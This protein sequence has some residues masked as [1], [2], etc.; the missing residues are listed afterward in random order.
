MKLKNI[1]FGL[2]L[3][4]LLALS[5]CADDKF[6]E[7]RTDMTKNLKEYQYLNNY[8]PLKKYVEDMKASGKCNPD[9]KLGIALA[10]PDFN[11][12][13]LV[14][15]LAGSNF[16]EMTAGNAMKYASCVKDDGTFDF[17]TVKDF[18]TNAKDAGLTI[19][20]HTLA[21]H[22][23]QNK[24]YLSKL[25]AD[26][27]IQ[28]DP[29]QKEEKTDYQL[30]CSTLTKY[31]WFD[32][33]ASSVTTEWNKDGAVVITN[34]EPIEPFYKLQYWLV[35]GI[36]L[37]EGKDYK[38]TIECKAEG[39]S[40]ANIHFKLGD[41]NV[42]EQQFTIP[43]G[44]GY[45]KVVLS[46]SPKMANNGIMF[47]HG[48]FAGKIYWKSIT[49]SHMETPVME[50][51]STV[52]KLD[53]EGEESLG[54]WGMDHTP[55]NV[56]GVCQVGN[57]AA[58]SAD[59]NAQVNFEP[60]FIFE[61]GTTYHLKMKIKGSVAGQFGALFQNPDGY[62][63]CGNFQNISVT[64][65]WKEVDVTAK[66]NGD[67]ASRLLLNIGL[68]AG[69]L[70]IDDFEVYITK[71]ANSIPLTDEEK[72]S[73]LTDAMGKWI[74][75]MME[76]TD[77]YVTSWDVVNEALSG[78]DKDGD[79]K[80]DLQHAATASADDKKN[81]FY[82]QDYLGDIDY[83][84]TAVAA[85]RK[86]FAAHNG[87]PDKLKLFINDYNL[88]S[89]WDE[90]AKLESLKKWIDD[91]EA[92]GV[93][94]IDGIASQMHI[95]CYADPNTQKSKK[96]HIVKMLELMA[97]SGKLCKISELDMGYVDAA[98]NKLTYDQMTEEQHKEMRDLYTFVLQKYFEII[99]IDQQYGITQ[100]CA[101]DSPKDSGWRPGEPTGLWDLNYLRKHTYAGFA[102]GLGAP[103]Y[104]NDAK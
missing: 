68:Y 80:Y 101:T 62:K 98:G 8:E 79:G 95:T 39:A 47:Q 66:C 28:V 26:K 60:G 72:K 71:S 12:Q 88:E 58:K 24:T 87:D 21:W 102:A 32:P 25:I 27:E 49:I 56:N 42:A 63:P 14:Y 41:W 30:D 76:A 52:A 23:Q 82:W 75:G 45:Q 51:P 4:A 15:C 84:R 35:N 93:T 85:A 2:G 3:V 74:D 55:E 38:L 31:D 44:K 20:G 100:W 96:D 94:K 86:S 6:S 34:P 48:D 7:Y 77:G 9:F 10:A 89:D 92:D 69:T 67:G 18:V 57:D 73:L 29:S 91:W 36:S 83:V 99:P 5:S 11:K 1:N 103:E 33:S 81:C 54:G 64:K 97:E 40:D 37:D 70:Y 16:E 90:N 53:F 104:W 43:V 50:I 65:D 17:N 59:W 19:Y 22:S 78:D 13:E 61:N 46:V